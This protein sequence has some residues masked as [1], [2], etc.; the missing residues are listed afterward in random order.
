[1]IFDLHIHSKYSFDSMSDP[2]KIIKYAKKKGLDGIAITDH[3]TIEGGLETSK[4]NKDLDFLVI[5]G[6]EISTELGDVTGLFLN[7]EI[8]SKRCVEVIEEIKAQGGIIVLPHPFRGHK[9]I[10][11]ISKYIDLIEVFNSR[12]SFEENKKA[13]ELAKKLKKKVIVGSDAHSL[14]EIG[15]AT[16]SFEGKNLLKDLILN[17]DRKILSKVYTSKHLKVKSY[18]IRALKLKE[19]SKIP[20]Y[21]SLLVR[22]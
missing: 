17:G 14:R 11:E 22:K 7:E 12:C 15:F 18:L 16:I 2:K 4:I 13:E 1:M 10:A 3:N 19:Y 9:N 20:Y 21:L 8:E 5:A 6:A